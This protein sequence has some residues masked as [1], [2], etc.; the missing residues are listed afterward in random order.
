MGVPSRHGA[1]EIYTKLYNWYFRYIRNT[2]NEDSEIGYS[3]LNNGGINILFDKLRN[4]PK[5]IL[6]YRFK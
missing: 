1:D 3:P 5:T 6:Y 4:L 2:P